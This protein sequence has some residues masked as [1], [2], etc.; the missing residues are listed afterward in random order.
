MTAPARRQPRSLLPDF[1]DLFEMFPSLAAMRPVFDLHT[2]RVEDKV[3]EGRYVL[4]AELPGVD[5]SKDVDIT[6]HNG[7][8]TIEAKRSEEKAEKGRSEFRYGSF[9]RTV[10]LPAG[11]QEDSIEATY[12]DGILTV[13][14]GLGEPEEPV[15]H[16][17]V[18]H[19]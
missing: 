9:S 1:T 14:V 17:K 10:T 16:I 11:A 15:K 5:A 2:I 13:T 6:V 19:D 18:N 7:L 3:E 4:R 8:L 12:T